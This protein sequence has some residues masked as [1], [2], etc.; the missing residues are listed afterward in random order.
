MISCDIPDRGGV[1]LSTFT[2]GCNDEPLVELSV[3]FMIQYDSD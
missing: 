1:L 3:T 2:S